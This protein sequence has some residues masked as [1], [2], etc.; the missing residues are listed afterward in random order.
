MACRCGWRASLKDDVLTRPGRN[1]LRKGD[2]NTP[3][4]YQRPPGEPGRCCGFASSFPCTEPSV[5]QGPSDA[6]RA[7]PHSA[8]IYVKGPPTASPPAEISGYFRRTGRRSRGESLSTVLAVEPAQDGRHATRASHGVV[9]FPTQGQTVTT[10]PGSPLA[11]RCSVRHAGR[12][13]HGST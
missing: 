12:R 8:I 10:S 2:D 5:A 4:K 6:S 9:H 11:L 7:R 13:A 3:Q 1:G